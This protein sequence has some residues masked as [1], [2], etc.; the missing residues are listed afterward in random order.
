VSSHAEGGKKTTKK[1]KAF[2]PSLF[3]KG[4]IPFLRAWL[5]GHSHLSKSLPL[6]TSISGILFQHME[7]FSWGRGEWGDTKTQTLQKGTEPG[8][9]ATLVRWWLSQE[10]GRRVYTGTDKD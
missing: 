8:R 9:P 2:P 1:Q 6:T 10:W 3:Y 7:V 5:S 4:A